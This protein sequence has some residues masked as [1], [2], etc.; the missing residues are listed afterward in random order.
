MQSLTKNE[1]IFS[2]GYQNTSNRSI[3]LNFTYSDV[4][5]EGPINDSASFIMLDGLQKGRNFEWLLTL[6]Q[7]I[8]RNLQLLINYNGRKTGD[9]DVVHFGNMQIKA[10]F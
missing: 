10:T 9:L 3:D 4:D 1:V 5:F 8:S 7:Q 2:L 6:N